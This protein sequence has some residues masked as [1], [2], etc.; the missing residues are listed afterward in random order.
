MCAP[1]RLLCVR[2]EDEPEDQVL[3]DRSEA[4]VQEVLR[5]VPG[6]VP[7]SSAQSSRGHAQENHSITSVR[8]RL[9]VLQGL[10]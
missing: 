5:Q 6:R 10:R 1:L 2:P 8:T 3:R 9:P 4:G 7:A